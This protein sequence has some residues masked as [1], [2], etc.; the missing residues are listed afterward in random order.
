MA[1][2]LETPISY[3]W[4]S[5]KLSK[6]KICLED[7][8]KVITLLDISAEIN[9][10]IKKL[11]EDANLA[12]RQGFK[13]DLVSYTGHSWPFLVFC[14]DVEVAIGGLKTRY[15]IFEIEIGDQDLVLGQPFFNSVKFS[16]KYKLDGILGNITHPHTHKMAI[17][18]TLIPQDLVNQK[19]NQIFCQSLNNLDGVYGV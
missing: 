19:E 5:I 12:M 11:I 14:K 17:F 8:S 6:A 7:R 1:K 10:M 3:F 4:Y 15:P 9:V 2:V 16:Q 18:R 13:L